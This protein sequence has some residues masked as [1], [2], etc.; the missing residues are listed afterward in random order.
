[1]TWQPGMPVATAADLADWQ[2][3]RRDRRRQQQRERRATNP[4]IDY[5]PST[6]AAALIYGLRFPG[7]EGDLSSVINRIVTE[8]SEQCDRNTERAVTQQVTVESRP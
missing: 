6:E 7:A 8:W 1:M 4:R 2:R 5:Y 3:W